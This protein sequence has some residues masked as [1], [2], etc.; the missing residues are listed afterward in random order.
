MMNLDTMK[1]GQSEMVYVK[2]AHIKVERTPRGSYATV[3][4]GKFTGKHFF[5]STPQLALDCLVDQIEDE[6]ITAACEICANSE[7][8]TIENLKRKTWY[9]GNELVLCPSCD[10]E[11]HA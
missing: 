11:N 5:A 2:N 7:T 8:G 6:A 3:K 9:I 1:A 10:Y 4:S